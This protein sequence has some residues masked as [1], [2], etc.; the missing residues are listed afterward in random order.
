MDLVLAPPQ[1]PYLGEVLLTELTVG[2]VQAMFTAIIRQHQ[3][4]GTPVSAATLPRI[5]AT[6]LARGAECGDPAGPDHRQ[7]GRSGGAAAGAPG[8]LATEPAARPP[9]PTRL[10]NRPSGVAGMLTASA[11]RR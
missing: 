2:Q 11:G 9:Q 8:V 4:L 5:R 1:A 7:P 10:T 3:A 6:L